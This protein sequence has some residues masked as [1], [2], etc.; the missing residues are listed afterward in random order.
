M[1]SR[2]Q[3]SPT[4]LLESDDTVALF[5][6]KIPYLLFGSTP[7]NTV[8]RCIYQLIATISTTQNHTVRIVRPDAEAPLLAA[9]EVGVEVGDP[10]VVHR[11]PLAR[12]HHFGHKHWLPIVGHKPISGHQLPSRQPTLSLNPERVFAGRPD[13][14]PANPHSAA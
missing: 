13:R 8:V 6:R 10:Q 2:R 14:L 1:R 9:D 3:D 11:L 4:S 12:I 7:E 5:T